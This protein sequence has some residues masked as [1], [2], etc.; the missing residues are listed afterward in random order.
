MVRSS[1]VPHPRRT[2]IAIALSAVSVALFA[3][4]ASV[5]EGPFQPVL[6]TGTVP[7]G[8]FHWVAEIGRASCR[9]RV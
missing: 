4:V 2:S 6:P 1:T 5:P 7:T 8:P 9:D 3:T